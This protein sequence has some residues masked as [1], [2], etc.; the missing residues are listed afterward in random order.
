[1]SQSWP[2]L[3]AMPTTIGWALVHLL[4]QG[5]VVAGG[6]AIV[7]RLLRPCTA[8]ARYLAGCAALLLMVMC[9]LVTASW[10]ASQSAQRAPAIVAHRLRATVDASAVQGTSFARA[11]P[12][13]GPGPVPTETIE[14]S[15]PR[16]HGRISQPGTAL[17]SSNRRGRSYGQRA[18]YASWRLFHGVVE[19]A[20]P[21]VV[22]VWLAGVLVLSARLAGGF[23][24]ARRLTICDVSAPFPPW[25]EILEQLTARMHVRRPVRLLLS[26]RAAT[27]I[28]VGWLRPV[29]LLPAAAITGLAPYQIEA[30]LAHELAHVRRYDYVVNLLQS[31]LEVLLFYHPSVW[32]ISNCVR[33]DREHCCDEIAADSCGDRI[34]YAR[35]LLD[36]ASRVKPSPRLALGV[37]GGSLKSRIRHILGGQSTRSSPT[38]R[39]VNLLVIGLVLLAV[40]VPSVPVVTQLVV[41]HV[42]RKR[43]REI[44]PQVTWLKLR[45]LVRKGHSEPIALFLNTEAV[46]LHR[47]DSRGQTLLHHSMTLPEG[48]EIVSLLLAH[49]ADTGRRDKVG[50]TPLHCYPG[51]RE[52][53]QVLLDHGVPL[54]VFA[55]SG[56][57]MLTE[58]DDLLRHD[59]ALVTATDSAGRQPLDHAAESD[60][61]AAAQL[62]IER[63]A[64]PDL[65]WA[66]RL[67]MLDRVTEMLSTDPTLADRLAEGV[68]R[69]ALHAAVLSGS[70]PVVEAL[71]A[72]GAD[73]EGHDKTDRRPLRLALR[74]DRKD[75]V[76]LLTG[77]GAGPALKF[78][79]RD[80]ATG[81]R[82]DGARVE[83]RLDES[84]QLAATGPQG[85]AV[86][87]LPSPLPN[88]LQ[89][90][91]RPDGYVPM[92]V[93]W[94]ALPGRRLNIPMEYELSVERGTSIGGRV[95]DAAG[96]GIEGVTLKLLVL[97]SRAAEQVAIRDHAVSTDAEGRWQCDIMPAQLDGLYVR[98]SHPDYVT[99]NWYDF[100]QTLNVDRLR[101]MT[102]VK[103]MRQ[104]QVVRGIVLDA[105]SGT[106]IADATVLDARNRWG[107][108][109]SGVKTDEGGEFALLNPKPGRIMLTVTSPGYAPQM[110]LVELDEDQGSLEFR[111][112]PGGVV[113]GRVVDRAGRP[114]EG[115]PVQ[116]ATWHGQRALDW[117]VHTDAEGCF[118]WHD[119][120]P[121]PVVLSVRKRGYMGQNR[122]VVTPRDEEYVVTLDAVITVTGRITDRVSGEPITKF[123]LFEG[124][125]YGAEDRIGRQFLGSFTQPDGRYELTLSYPPHHGYFVY[126]ESE[127]YDASRSPQFHY[128]DGPQRFDLTLAPATL[129]T[130]VVRDV[131]GRQLDNV[132]VV[133]AKTTMPVT[134][135]NGRPRLARSRPK[136]TT[137]VHGGFSVAKPKVPYV[138]VAV[139]DDGYAEMNGER[140][141][142]SPSLTL[143][144]WAHVEGVMRIGTSPAVGH[145]ANALVEDQQTP[146]AEILR[147]D[148]SATVDEEG[149]FVLDRVPPG[150]AY[151]GRRVFFLDQHTLCYG[152]T[153]AV[154]LDLLPGLTAQVA[155][156]GAG[157]AVIGRVILPAECASTWVIPVSWLSPYPDD[158]SVRE[159]TQVPP[160]EWAENWNEMSAIA[161][162]DYG[163]RFQRGFD[164]GAYLRYRDRRL[165]ERGCFPVILDRAGW[166]RIEDVPAG[167]YVLNV[168][169]H[170]LYRE[171]AG[172]LGPEPLGILSRRI[173]VSAQPAD[174]PVILETMEMPV[175]GAAGD[176]RRASRTTW[177][178]Q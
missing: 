14:R 84:T 97:G 3:S 175:V 70:L 156:G 91:C 75:I 89:L 15:R 27:P 42:S 59:P 21:Y 29:I 38:R 34:A 22:V 26:A 81:T 101:D 74:A 36:V 46:D 87:D 170:D 174:D 54:D 88:E 71:L 49:G 9:P 106:P 108:R 111:L 73:P 94:Q 160:T 146:V 110:R 4:W 48:A 45:T 19:S 61:V 37:A 86:I 125:I 116:C 173:S 82:L 47:A 151:V 44:A 5:L 166:L 144:P 176:E 149:R 162:A 25:P 95:Y 117:L 58:L 77:R 11:T 100:R 12:E 140:F 102:W 142:R 43:E 28:V 178:T 35:T 55:A 80:R 131:N 13:R 158:P 120:P 137:N 76:A 164:F 165:A 99:E 85:L 72:A 139:S 93:G 135:V 83:I 63:G 169:V 16:P 115:A 69:T 129:L 32:W 90:T 7:R 67:G 103:V 52:S 50:R 136:V 23:R 147:H 143:A 152:T 66:A 107:R 177:E 31:V 20:L 96:A 105:E 134:V 171:A 127:G 172:T 168:D 114:I 159:S 40:I 8:H 98:L 112:S 161:K 53:V 30:L 62:L 2:S 57:G 132:E 121:G 64:T 18:A 1:M 138:I 113:R 24:Y 163:T 17:Q 68:L 141:E 104:S 154:S 153:H 157:R 56:H 124:H 6:F 126:V 130:G 60:Q 79:V 39:V 109:T 33:A 122:L 128:E 65:I 92:Q 78:H 150:R 51:P 119:A 155:I 41:T 148:I 123:N 133:I 10:L 167:E 145:T 118:V